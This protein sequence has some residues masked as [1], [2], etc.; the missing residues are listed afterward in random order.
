RRLIAHGWSAC[1]PQLQTDA[2]QSFR[3]RVEACDCERARV[4]GDKIDDGIGVIN[5]TS[6]QTMTSGMIL[7]QVIETASGSYN[8]TA[9]SLSRRLARHR[10]MFVS[11]EVTPMP[12]IAANY[13]TSPK[14]PIGKWVCAPT[15]KLAPFSDVPGDAQTR[16][17]DFCGQCVSYVKV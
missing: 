6:S 11:G 14:A 8:Q 17:P 10:P 5:R 1:R 16:A 12:Y 3:R 9:R 13:A 4:D 15:S 2:A 7:L